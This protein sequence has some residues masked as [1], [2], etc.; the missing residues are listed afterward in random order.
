MGSQFEGQETAAAR[1]SGDD[2]YPDVASRDDDDQDTLRLQVFLAHAGLCSRRGAEEMIA[3]GR[4]RVNG[5]LVKER[6][7][8]VKPED[9][10]QVDGKSV[11][12]V[13]KKIYVALN[14]PIGYVCSN[15]D[16]EGRALAKD[17]IHSYHDIRLFSVGRLDYLSAGLIFFT[18]DGAFSNQVSHPR[19]GVEKEYE[20]EAKK[21]ISDE[22]LKEFMTGIYAA[23]E[24]YR[25]SSYRRIGPRKVSLVL[26]EGKN[27]EIRNAFAAR[28]LTIKSLVRTRIGC[29]KLGTMAPGTWRALQAHEIQW[30]VDQE[31]PHGRGN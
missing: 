7:Y 8:R 14:K 13:Q 4:V 27:R 26:K 10:I 31:K 6:G 25:I 11:K 30:F 21:E 19:A 15:D 5:K 2:E 18:N 12:P 23:G 24:R 29:V 20:V 9:N 22:F 1:Q 28:K 16:P 3:L 17:L